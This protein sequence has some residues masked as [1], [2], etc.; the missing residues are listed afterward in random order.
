MEPTGCSLIEVFFLPS[1]V[2]VP[3]VEEL[4]FAEEVILWK[5][6]VVKNF[7]CLQSVLKYNLLNQLQLWLF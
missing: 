2:F 4:G 5:K 6:I 3:G 1:V 7:K